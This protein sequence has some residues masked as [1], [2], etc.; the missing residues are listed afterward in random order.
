[1]ELNDLTYYAYLLKNDM[2]H[3]HLHCGGPDFDKIHSLTQELYEELDKEIDELAEMAISEG[4][5]IES[6]SNVKS[7][8]DESQWEPEN[9]TV[10]YWDS[11]IKALE[12][13]GRK[14]LDA[15][16]ETSTKVNVNRTILDEF[17]KFWN[18][19]INFKNVAR[20]LNDS[21]GS[22]YIDAQ[23]E[24]EDEKEFEA[25]DS[26]SEGLES[27]S[28]DLMVTGGIEIDP[29]ASTMFTSPYE[30]E[31]EEKSDEESEDK[32]EEKE[33]LKDKEEDDDSK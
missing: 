21:D 27:M 17:E 1:M 26:E 7:F 6:F 30:S 18:K 13:K 24:L 29:M 8:I 12:D 20:T 14:Y 4:C 19:E 32:S 31:S 5:S 25:D 28:T 15:L 3:I 9:E 33:E 11:F 23:V 2:H 22:T 16:S 10:Y